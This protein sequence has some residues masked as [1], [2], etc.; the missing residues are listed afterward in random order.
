MTALPFH[1][2]VTYSGLLFFTYQFMPSVPKLVYD[3]VGKGTVTSQ[4]YQGVYPYAMP[5]LPQAAHAPVP[6]VPLA[7]LVD[8]VDATWGK[9][10]ATAVEVRHPGDANARVLVKPQETT[11]IKAPENLLVFDGANGSLLEDFRPNDHAAADTDHVMKGLHKGLFADWWLRILFL[12]M[13][14]GGTAMVGTGLLLWA[15]TRRTRLLEKHKP[16]HFGIWLVDRLN[17]GTVIGVPIAIA[18][19]FWANRLLPVGLEGRAAW[20][21]HAMYL[22]MAAGFA[23]PM[24]RQ[25]NRARVEMLWLC[26]AAYAL[27]PVL[28]ALTTHRHLGVSIPQGDWIMAG[29]DLT[30]IGCGAVAAAFALRVRR[31]MATAPVRRRS[32]AHAAGGAPPLASTEAS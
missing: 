7:S 15:N 32:R 4:F 5:S 31:S 29:F 11:S 27:L 14:I 13:G 23:Y 22:T 20:E 2:V 17:V 16:L 18:A 25:F 1:L 21:V 24:V 9:G 3:D 10:L 19:Y 28:N 30:A 12:F 26:A 6:L 8:T